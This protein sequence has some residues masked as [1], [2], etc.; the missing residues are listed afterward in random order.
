M[1]AFQ[2]P[3]NLFTLSVCASAGD[4]QALLSVLHELKEEVRHVRQRIDH[5][6]TSEAISQYPVGKYDCLLEELQLSLLVVEAPDEVPQSG[7][8]ST[9]FYMWDER[10]EPQQSE[11][12]ISFLTG[13]LK[14]P[15]SCV[16]RAIDKR[17][18]FLSVHA[19]A[20]GTTMGIKGTSD[21][22]VLDRDFE[23]ALAPRAGIILL[24]ELKKE[25]QERDARQAQLQTISGNRVSQFRPVVV[26]TD[27]RESWRYYWIKDRNLCMMSP[28]SALQAWD[29]L[30]ALLASHSAPQ[31]DVSAVLSQD[32]INRTQLAVT[33][34]PA[35]V[36]SQHENDDYQMDLL[37][38]EEREEAERKHVMLFAAEHIPWM[39][40]S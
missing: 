31:S 26:L 20:L 37:T 27:L 19:N 3:L 24:F 5:D 29:I 39:M 23:N 30:N 8:G 11:D 16:L 2:V 21:L 32:L 7:S 10:T 1:Q 13:H 28:R 25:I 33:Q 14:F 6:D 40:Y 15:R 12:C 36:S 35:N 22:A 38:Q 17:A 4:H 9:S 34:K 18:D